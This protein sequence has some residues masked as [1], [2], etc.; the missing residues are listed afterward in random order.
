[1]TIPFEIL[2]GAEWKGQ[3]L[4]CHPQDLK[5]NRPPVEALI[6]FLFFLLT[7]CAVW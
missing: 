3:I 6:H 7:L 2:M 1:M 5:W 4:F